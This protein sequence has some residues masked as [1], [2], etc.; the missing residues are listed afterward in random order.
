MH[1]QE[2]FFFFPKAQG[3]LDGYEKIHGGGMMTSWKR[4]W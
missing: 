3:V 1:L 2:I 4:Q